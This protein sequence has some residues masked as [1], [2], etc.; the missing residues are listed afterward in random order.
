M[1]VILS[2]TNTIAEFSRFTPSAGS[3]VTFTGKAFGPS[4]GAAV[5][6]FITFGYIVAAATIVSI[7]GVWVA[8]TLRTF[9]GLSIHW[10]ILTVLITVATGWLVMPRGPALDFLVW[11][12]LL[13]RGRASGL[14]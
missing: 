3:F 7:A 1:V 5:S 11:R 6:V 8:E 14:G 10:S 12:L 13:F 2:L 9:L 4:V